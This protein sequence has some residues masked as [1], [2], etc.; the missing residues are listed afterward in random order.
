M[1]E[2]PF[3]RA[4]HRIIRRIE[5]EDDRRGRRRM[6]VHKHID[7]QP[8]HRVVIG[9]DLLVAL[10]RAERRRAEFEAI[11][12]AFAG[13]RGVKI[14]R[15]GEYGHQRIMAERV[16]IIQIFIPE[17]QAVHALPHQLRD[18]ARHSLCLA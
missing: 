16:V 7:E 13:A 10:L 6:R 3:L 4:V 17:R 11:E 2:A 15:L 5:I 9:G 1:K 18:R 14:G 12:R 8:I